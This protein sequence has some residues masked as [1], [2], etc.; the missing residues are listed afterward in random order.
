MLWLALLVI[1]AVVLG[2]LASGWAGLLA[3]VLNALVWVGF[4]VELA[5][6]LAVSPSRVR[7]LRAH[8]LDAAIVVVSVPVVPAA[9]QGAR[10]L[11][12]L[13]VLRLLRL[14]LVGGRSLERARR[15]FTP[16][17]VRYLAVL[18]GFFVVVAG[19]LVASVDPA[20][21]HSF[22]DGIWWALATITTVGYGDVS[23]GSPWGRAVGA[24]VMLLGIGFFAVLTAAV[25]A[26]FVKQDERSD[27]VREQL[28]EL[29]A[30]LERIETAL[31]RL[32][33]AGE[34]PVDG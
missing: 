7:T 14:A 17:G 5:F 12:L 8:W 21:V 22:S 24:V 27:G 3:L 29:A 34:R 2:Q 33:A 6:V 31:G 16:G 18:I 23:P 15:L 4:A 20:D 11:R 19:A 1:P 30:R 10:A 13:R 28:D 26:T 25:S 32:T 9:L